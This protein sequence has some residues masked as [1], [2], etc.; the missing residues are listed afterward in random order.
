MTRYFTDAAGAYLGG[1]DGPPEGLP[2]HLQGQTEVP[3]APEN[4]AQIWTGSGWG[5]VPPDT[6]PASLEARL[7][8]VEELLEEKSVFTRAER[9]SKVDEVRGR[10]RGR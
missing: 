7:G 10:G 1:Y 9:Q 5:P 3:T 6:A 8:A 4:A 2:A